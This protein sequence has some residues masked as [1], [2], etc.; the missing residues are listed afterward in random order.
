MDSF[1]IYSQLRPLLGHGCLKI[2]CNQEEMN[3]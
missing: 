2:G 1:E 3:S